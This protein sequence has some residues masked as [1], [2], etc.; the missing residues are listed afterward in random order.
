M[1][2]TFSMAGLFRG[3]LRLRIGERRKS[4]GRET[5]MKARTVAGLMAGSAIGIA[6]G[7]GVM[8][9]P[10]AKR[11]RKA[12]EKGANDIGRSIAGWKKQ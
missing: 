2:K 4:Q 9:M 8:M 1:P 3:K 5:R 12:I 6:I 11:M 7:A 10:H